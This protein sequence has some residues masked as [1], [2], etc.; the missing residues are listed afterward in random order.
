VKN[1]TTVSVPARLGDWGRGRQR[2]VEVTVGDVRGEAPTLSDVKAEVATRLAELAEGTW[3]PRMVRSPHAPHL[4]VLLYRH[5][6]GGWTY[7]IVDFTRCPGTGQ[8]AADLHGHSYGQEPYEQVERRAR[9]HFAQYLATAENGFDPVVPA[10]VVHHPD[11]R[12]DLA[13]W[14]GFQRAWRHAK[15]AGIVGDLHAWALEHRAEFTP[16]LPPTTA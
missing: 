4:L 14:L 2:R 10:S 7:R 12:R 8:R 11:D 16:E 1:T 5:G 15:A 6:A 9:M 13:D 3:T